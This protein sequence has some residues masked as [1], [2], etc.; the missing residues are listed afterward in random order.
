MSDV[1]GGMAGSNKR[2]YDFIK[3]AHNE[4]RTPEEIIQNIK[5]KI[6]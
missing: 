3:P 6:V 1:L 5:N 4:T 2:Y